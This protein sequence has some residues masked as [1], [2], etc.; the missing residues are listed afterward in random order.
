M[1]TKYKYLAELKPKQRFRF[2]YQNSKDH[3][4]QVEIVAKWVEVSEIGKPNSLEIYHPKT[5]V[6]PA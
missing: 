5:L 6:I 3:L 1:N 4:Y 2:R